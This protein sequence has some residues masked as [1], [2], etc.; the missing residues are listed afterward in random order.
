[1]ELAAVGIKVEGIQGADKAADSLDKLA[2]AGDSAKVSLA[3]AGTASK[4]AK[5]SIDALGA[6]SAKA[7]QEQA[8]LEAMA[9]QSGMSV[10]AMKA[11]LR[12]VP[13]QFT[14]IA[15]SLQGGMNPLT[16]F[17]QQGGQL[18]DMFGGAIPA[19]R[20]LGGYILGLINPLTVAASAV[21]ALGVAYYS[22]SREADRF[23]I[24]LAETGSASG[25]TVGD[26]QRM[27]EAISDVRGTTG[28][29][30]EALATMIG[31]GVKAEG[32]LKQYTETALAWSRATGQGV[33]VVAE[34]F[35]ALQKDPVS[36]ALKLN[37]STNFLTASL[38]EQIKALDEQGK[39]SEASALAMDAFERSMAEGAANIEKNLGSLE[40]GWNAV[41]GAAKGAWDWMLNIGRQ[42]TLMERLNE[43]Q[44][45]LR[46]METEIVGLYE[47]GTYAKRLADQRARVTALLDEV[48]AEEINASAKKEAA[49]QVEEKV[50]KDKEL[51]KFNA[52]YRGALESQITLEQHL[53]KVREDAVKVGKSEAEIQK[54]LAYETEQYNK[55]HQKRTPGAGGISELA[56]IQ[57][58]VH[59]TQ[60]LIKALQEQGAAAEQITEGERLA[61]KIQQEIDSGRLNAAQRRQKM[62]ELEAAQMLQAAEEQVRAERQRIDLVEK[63]K[64]AEA[65]RVNTLLDAEARLQAMRDKTAADLASYG[66]GARAAAEMRE[67]L[68]IE[69]E[70]LRQV[71]EM[72]RQHGEEMRKA[73]SDAERAFL[74]G[75]FQERLL[76]TQNG[77]AA[78]LEAY[79]LSLQQ[80]REKEQEWREGFQASIETYIEQSENLYALAYDKMNGFL[81][82]VQNSIS[83]NFMAMIDGTKSVGDAFS[84]MARG[85]VNA[86][87]GALVEM[88][89]QWLVYK[90]V[91]LAV[92]K[93]TGVAAAG[94]MTAIAQAQSMQAG[95]SAYA[96][97]AAIPIVGPV[98]APA[99]MAAALAA[100][101]PLAATVGALSLAGMAHDGIDSIPETGT[102]LLEKGERVTTADTSARLDSVL[103]RVDAKLDRNTSNAPN[104]T[105]NIVG[106]PENARVEQR[107]VSEEEFIIDVVF[108]D[109]RNGGRLSDGFS[110]TFGLARQGV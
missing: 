85:M 37:E 93:S 16:V 36:A 80:K 11:A 41:A 54:L 4:G 75:M 91:Q 8:K 53:N 42:A 74:E 47:R 98:L 86:I 106:G 18:K 73:E 12:G 104:V 19:A 77:F 90:A 82:N 67:R 96:S 33:D 17:L 29:A 70:Q 30:A 71:A 79:D 57:A 48:A 31:A 39:S 76:I 1:M 25:Q 9:R 44:E 99:A 49:R 24:A 51:E 46:K 27:A 107:Q 15:I 68:S 26:L 7:A 28:A 101:Q 78:E 58:R 21:A 55:K 6:A 13:A 34:R 81:S 60:Q 72:R 88:A 45:K 84:D 38:Y 62:R 97:T 108:S 3:G 63:A 100:T 2:N 66:M 89:A 95:I 35:V 105:V 14:D 22:G 43:E 94:Q 32:Q 20:A 92:G 110:Q 23:R 65:D 64:A 5:P 50:R 56:N 87:V 61:Y 102:W 103:S 52:K 83:S 59:A 109:V 10:N 40:R 69:Q